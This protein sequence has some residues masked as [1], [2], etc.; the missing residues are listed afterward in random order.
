MYNTSLVAWGDDATDKEGSTNE[1]GATGEDWGRG[2]LK[3]TEQRGI[4]QVRKHNDLQ[5][6]IF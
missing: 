4:L 6:Y 5:I 3:G 1:D 2:T